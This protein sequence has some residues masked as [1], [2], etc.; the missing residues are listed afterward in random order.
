MKFVIKKSSDWQYFFTIV[1]SNGQKLCT[2][3]TYTS[4]ESAKHTIQSIQDNAKD[5][6][7]EDDT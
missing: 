4:K 2:S 7:V 3:E 6:T 1:A 5:A